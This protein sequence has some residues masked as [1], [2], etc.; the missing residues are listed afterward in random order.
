MADLMR[1]TLAPL[2]DTKEDWNAKAAR[3]VAEHRKDHPSA[4]IVGFTK[5][6][7]S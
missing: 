3:I 7:P 6:R 4:V 5:R 2:P 1:A